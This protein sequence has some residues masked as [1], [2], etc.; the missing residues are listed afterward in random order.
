MIYMNCFIFLFS[1]TALS[2]AP[3]DDYLK[4][5]ND[6][7]D[8]GAYLDAIRF[9]R[10]YQASVGVS[11]Q[12]H[13]IQQAEECY[14]LTLLADTYFN[15]L[16]YDKAEKQYTKIVEINPKDPHA[17]ARYNECISKRPKQTIF[18]EIYE[19]MVLISSDTFTMGCSD[20]NAYSDEQ[21]VHQVTVSDFKINKYQVTQKQWKEVMGNESNFS[22]FKG[23][24]LPVTNVSWNDVQDFIQELNRRTGKTYRL[25]T[26][27]EWEF[28]A[29]GGMNRKNFTYAGS[30]NIDEVGWY[31]GNSNNKTHP[32]GSIKKGN[33]LGLFDMSGNVWEWCSN[34]Y[35]AYTNAAQTNPKGPASGSL[36]VVRGGCWNHFPWYCRVSSRSGNRPYNR[37]AHIGF[38]LCLDR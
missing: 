24:D 15:E 10:T 18:N 35:G 12:Y 14:G 26:E 4:Q 25:P 30:N 33:E 29:R 9:Y 21:P 28:A 3:Q 5:A 11:T 16:A 19:N 8:R 36:R 1:I 34:W 23:D 22:E 13:K 38:R 20:R 31:S 6:C 2:F 7:F 17:K 37:Y 32:V 27:A